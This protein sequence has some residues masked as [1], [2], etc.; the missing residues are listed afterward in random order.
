MNDPWH[1]LRRFTQARIAL[2][3]A[4]SGVTTAAYLEFQLAH[5]GAR[6]AVQQTWNVDDFAEQLQ[7][8]S[9]AHIRLNTPVID[10]THYLRRPDL[11]RRLDD[12]SLQRLKQVAEPGFDVAIV[13]SNGLSSTAVETHG[14]PLL[15]RI[16]ARYTEM[17]LSIAPICL[18]PNARVAI[19][20]PIGALLHARLSVIVVGERPGLSAADSLGVYMTYAPREGNTDAERNCLSNIRPPDGLSYEA[21]AQKLAYLSREALRSGISGVLLKDD[22]PKRLLG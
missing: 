4:G 5:A 3:R 13:I 20:D 16:V 17:Q 7:Q 9:L 21:A 8:Q 22:M 2:G 1:G 14:M 15:Q 12:D 6:D 18:L 11:G 19:S 10:R